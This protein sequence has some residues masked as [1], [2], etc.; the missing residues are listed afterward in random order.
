MK[1]MDVAAKQAELNVAMG[2][3]AEATPAAYARDYRK[4]I[5]FLDSNGVANDIDSITKPVIDDFIIW[6]HRQGNS[7]STIQRAIRALKVLYDFALEYSWVSANPCQSFHFRKDRT[8]KRRSLSDEESA[9]LLQDEGGYRR[10]RNRAIVAVFITTGLRSG[11]LRNLKWGDIDFGTATLTVTKAK[12][13]KSR[14]IP[15]GPETIRRLKEHLGG[16]HPAPDE[17]VFTSRL[18]KPL[19]KTALDSIIK[20]AAKRAGIDPKSI[21]NHTMRHSFV[22]RVARTLGLEVARIMAGHSDINTTALYIHPSEW[23]KRHVPGVFDALFVP[24]KQKEQQR[25]PHTKSQRPRKRHRSKK[26]RSAEK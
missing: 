20:R 13:N 6:L 8:K 11:E 26:R 16:R 9:A 10:P 21:C 5:R 23:E 17:P 14:D 22:T 3:W 2:K 19:S 7:A 12:E 15:L 4:F 25:H 1:I 18:Q 24:D